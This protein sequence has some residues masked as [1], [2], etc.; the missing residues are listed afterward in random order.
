MEVKWKE[1]V[2]GKRALITCSEGTG[3]V[4]DGDKKTRMT[5]G[6]EVCLS[7]EVQDLLSLFIHTSMLSDLLY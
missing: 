1:L 3:V 2:L 6:I 4:E 7:K 5:L